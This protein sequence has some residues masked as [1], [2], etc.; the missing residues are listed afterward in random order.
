MENLETKIADALPK[1]IERKDVRYSLLIYK[2]EWDGHQ[3]AWR[4]MYAREIK[5]NVSIKKPL[6]KIE[7]TT[8]LDA[9]Q[10]M[11]NEVEEFRKKNKGN[12]NITR[13]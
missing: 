7:G 3:S 4:I 10:K 6:L 5:N 11:Q 2:N 8:L 13:M 12:P 9:L 1:Y